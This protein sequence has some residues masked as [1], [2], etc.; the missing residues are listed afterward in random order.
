M[1]LVPTTPVQRPYNYWCSWGAQ[2]YDAR[3]TDG[4]P[5]PSMEGEL[6][7]EN[8]MQNLS[9]ER[10]FG[11]DG[12]TRGFP[13]EVRADVL[14]MLDV[15]WD[16][17]FGTKYPHDLPHF[18]AVTP[19]PDRWPSCTG[20]DRQRLTAL[21]QLA[22][23]HGWA[24]LGVWVAPQVPRWAAS[25]EP[26]LTIDDGVRA[27]WRERASR[28]HAAGVSYW[29]VDI[30][31]GA[32]DAS[33]RGMITAE[34]R[35][36]APELI[37]EHAR[38]CGPLNDTTVPWD[39]AVGRDTG[40]FEPWD[41]IAADARGLLPISDV[42]RAYDVLPQLATPTMLD[43]AAALLSS[44]KAATIINVEDEA[45]LAA[46]LGCSLGIMRHRDWKERPGEDYDPGL[47]RLRDLELVRALRWQRLAGPLAVG[48]ADLAVSDDV[49]EDTWLFQEGDAWPDF[50][51]GTT[52][53]QAAPAAVTRGIA[54][55]TVE[56]AH[57]DLPY[58]VASRWPNGVV[59]V[60]TLPRTTADRQLRTPRAEIGMCDMTGAHTVAI[61]GDIEAVS[62]EVHRRP[63]RVTIQ[64]LARDGGRD[65]TE[66]VCLP[67]GRVR[68]PGHLIRSV[69]QQATAH[70]SEP[71]VLLRLD[72]D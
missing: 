6:G 59:A 7:F 36:V 12:W 5:L 48:E 27:S 69:C 39:D 28:C 70:H 66:Q 32:L 67:E 1:N 50:L 8:A 25:G 43:R 42:V 24:G 10:V 22:R 64:D 4:G 9:E 51:A 17:P 55:P 11:P 52:V 40:R 23:A 47:V 30:G 15:G 41:C 62:W 37:V 13:S 2:N 60:A 53:R 21:V 68:L 35:A 33:Y 44:P 45:Y 61:F 29:K 3:M 19:D 49:L 54:L 72:F 18:G 20:D 46:A 16:L 58:V 57:G 38:N 26:P 31:A 63:R 14:L 65:V 56:P 34:A 71:A